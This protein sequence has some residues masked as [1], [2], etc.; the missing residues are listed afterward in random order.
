MFSGSGRGGFDGGRNTGRD[1]RGG[2]Q[3]ARGYQGG[4]R[5]GGGGGGRGRSTNIPNQYPSVCIHFARGN[6]QFDLK[7]KSIASTKLAH[8]I[9]A[10]LKFSAHS[11]GAGVSALGVIQSP[12]RLLTGSDKEAGIKVWEF[13]SGTPTH[14]TVLPTGGAVHQIEVVSNFVLW[15][16]LEPLFT[17]L[18]E[19]TVGRVHMLNLPTMDEVSILKS[20]DS[21]FT[22]ATEVRSFTTIIN[23]GVLYVIT[24][25]GDGNIR[26]WK[27][28]EASSAFQEVACLEGHVRAVSSLLICDSFLWSASADT[29]IKI[30]DISS[31]K[32]HATLHC[33][34]ITGAGHVGAVTCLKQM[35]ISPTP[36][37][38][39]SVVVSG[40]MDGFIK[41]WQLSGEHVLNFDCGT[42][43]MALEVFTD[44]LGGVPVLLAGLAD[45]KLVI[46]SCADMK[47]LIVVEGNALGGPVSP[48]NIIMTLSPPFPE[49]TF[50]MGTESGDVTI[51]KV[52]APLLP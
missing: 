27:F 16:A 20:L 28:D 40:G 24:G 43:V 32:I 9:F 36:E 35:L 45:G 15:S 2:R 38:A 13:D 14:E 21:P 4:G 46:F 11:S 3:T 41:I 18:P 25:G 44:N 49:N 51:W 8:S 26:I 7:C 5:S 23:S 52:I 10:L 47:I 34:D 22:S 50:V 39:S 17:T 42:G 29:M 12:L 33:D 30:W 31:F 37:Q 19:P 6:C 48:I 1:G